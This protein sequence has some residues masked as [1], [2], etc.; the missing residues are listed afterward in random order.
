MTSHF[1][2]SN[3]LRSST[4]TKT[5]PGQPGVI[6]SPGPTG[7][8][9]SLLAVPD[10]S[11]GQRSEK[12]SLTA[13]TRSQE[14]LCFTES[15][16][17]LLSTVY[18]GNSCIHKRLVSTFARFRSRFDAQTLWLKRYEMSLLLDESPLTSLFAFTSELVLIAFHSV[19]MNVISMFAHWPLLHPSTQGV[20]GLPWPGY[21]D[22]LD[23]GSGRRSPGGKQPHYPHS[24]GKHSRPVLENQSDGKQITSLRRQIADMPQ[25]HVLTPD[26]PWTLTG[27]WYPVNECHPPVGRQCTDLANTPSACFSLHVQSDIPAAPYQPG[28][29]CLSSSPL[30]D[31]LDWSEVSP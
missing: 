28:L 25:P 20:G 27:P 14:E 17:L 8:L 5:F 13:S 9:W 7:S 12:R 15:S 6:A 31:Q 30:T 11:T 16:S 26:P 3:L 10:F 21:K 2:S 4:V 23:L 22:P 18:R 29:P 19:L 24:E 1:F